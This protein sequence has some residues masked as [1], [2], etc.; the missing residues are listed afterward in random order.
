MI[1]KT[2]TAPEWLK[3]LSGII[4]STMA[5]GVTVTIFFYQNFET[6][7]AAETRALHLKELRDL[8]S[9]RLERIEE[10]LDRLLAR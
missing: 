9:K 7:S 10:K 4:L 2:V 3:W 6:V 1:K 8:D 5:T